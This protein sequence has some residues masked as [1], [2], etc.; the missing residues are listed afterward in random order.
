MHF[1]ALCTFPPPSSAAPL[2]LTGAAVV[3]VGLSVVVVAAAFVET[4]QLVIRRRQHCV[5]MS[6]NQNSEACGFFGRPLQWVSNEFGQLFSGT[7]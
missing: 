7:L 3:M 5:R 1:L 2:P 6:D 4:M